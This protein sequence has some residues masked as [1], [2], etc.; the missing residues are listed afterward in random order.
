[1]LDGNGT[2]TYSPQNIRTFYDTRPIRFIEEIE[3]MREEIAKEQTQNEINGKPLQ[4]N[5]NIYHLAS[6]VISREPIDKHMKLDLWFHPTDYYTV[7]AK[8]RCLKANAFREKYILGYDWDIPLPSLP[9]P[10][11]V[12]LSLLNSRWIYPLCSER[13]KFGCIPSLF[14]DLNGSRRKR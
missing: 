14:Y 3:H 11:G 6:F 4:W 2:E 1:M 13:K 12:G 7:L 10:F 5:G 9:I 8:N